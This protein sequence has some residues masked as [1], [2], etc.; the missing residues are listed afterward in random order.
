MG[1]EEAEELAGVALIGLQRI[2]REGVALRQGLPARR[3]VRPSD[4]RAPRRGQKIVHHPLWPVRPFLYT[5]L[6]Y[7]KAFEF[8]NDIA[9]MPGFG[10]STTSAVSCSSTS[11]S[12][13]AN[14]PQQGGFIMVSNHP[15]GIA[16]GVA[17][18]DCTK[19]TAP[20]CS[21][22]TATRSG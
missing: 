7:A 5:L 17:V 8:A 22:P 2:V 6:R 16:D 18:F 13:M 10:P 20:T 9:N 12:G 15:A 21:S 11:M 3:R 4:L 1:G 14:I 19:T